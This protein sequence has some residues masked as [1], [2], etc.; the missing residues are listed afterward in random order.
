[1]MA[2]G[3]RSNA[4]PPT[5]NESSV[6]PLMFREWKFSTGP[7]TVSTSPAESELRKDYCPY[8]CNP[9]PP[10]PIPKASKNPSAAR[11]AGVH[12]R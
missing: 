5:V 12:S 6:R 7:T 2:A 4:V 3:S 9:V 10:T 11:I 1:M 8:Q